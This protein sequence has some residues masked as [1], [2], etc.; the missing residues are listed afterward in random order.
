MERF[1][2]IHAELFTCFELVRRFGPFDTKPA[3]VL[4]NV[5][6]FSACLPEPLMVRWT[7]RKF[8]NCD[9]ELVVVQYIA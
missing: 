6:K 3:I 7:V 4:Y 8:R 5:W 2:I 9:S 1:R